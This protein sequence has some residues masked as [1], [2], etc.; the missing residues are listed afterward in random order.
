MDHVEP[1]QSAT[2]PDNVLQGAVKLDSVIRH[3]CE[4]G[5]NGGSAT[6][7]ACSPSRSRSTPVGHIIQCPHDHPANMMASSL[8][9]AGT[10]LEVR[11]QVDP[12]LAPSYNSGGRQTESESEVEAARCA[13]LEKGE[14][15]A[16]TATITRNIRMT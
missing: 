2:H 13:D 7:A 9:A 11:L 4:E 5:R 6:A 1:L 12:Q 14:T 3:V 15:S 10:S 8:S 16:G